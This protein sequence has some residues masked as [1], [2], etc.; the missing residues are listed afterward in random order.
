MNKHHRDLA[1]ESLRFH[2]EER[3]LN[4]ATR[5]ILGELILLGRLFPETSQERQQWE[6]Q[7]QKWLEDYHI[8]TTRDKQG[9]LIVKPP[10]AVYL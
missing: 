4:Y 6:A 9:L 5:C 1:L 7:G 2:D 8:H 3:T 10:P